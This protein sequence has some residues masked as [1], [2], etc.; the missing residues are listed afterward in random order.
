[1]GRI[2]YSPGWYWV[3]RERDGELEVAR[4][5]D[6]GDWLFSGTDEQDER[7]DSEGWGFYWIG[8]RL[9]PPRNAR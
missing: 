5:T 7:C 1:M 4:L 2:H 8:E 6:E 9:E 3:R